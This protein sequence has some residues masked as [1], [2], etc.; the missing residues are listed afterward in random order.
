MGLT[1]ERIHVRL[2]EASLMHI[3]ITIMYN[4]PIIQK[5]KLKLMLVGR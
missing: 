2:A 1:K 5:K 4:E 3:I